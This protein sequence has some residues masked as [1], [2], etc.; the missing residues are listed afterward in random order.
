MF[1]NASL[2]RLYEALAEQYRAA[3]YLAP[4]N[5]DHLSP[6]DVDLISGLTMSED[7]LTDENLFEAVRDYIY[8]FH[9]RDR[10]H[11][12]F[13]LSRRIKKAQDAG[14]DGELLRLLQQKNRLL[15]EGRT[16]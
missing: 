7:G 9:D 12:V 11:Q 14:D 13:D 10:K 2:G 6:D 5:L 3:G 1:Q 16:Q 15:K 4:E 8:K